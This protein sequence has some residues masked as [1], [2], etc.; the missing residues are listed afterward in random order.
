MEQGYRR[1]GFW[2]VTGSIIAG[3]IIAAAFAV[4]IGALVMVLWNWLMPVIFGLGTITYWQG[5]GLVL[6]AKLLFG[7][8]G[9]KG[10]DPERS[11]GPKDHWRNRCADWYGQNDRRHGPDHR[12]WHDRHFDDVYEEWWE[13]EGAAGFDAFMKKKEPG[14]NE[15]GA[16]GKQE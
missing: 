10:V 5:F 15:D 1:H 9:H 4:V 14:K 6:M 3:V 12:H 8:I 16:E 2:R 7:S 11:R 13:Q